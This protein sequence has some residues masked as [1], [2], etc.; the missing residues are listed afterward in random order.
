MSNAKYIKQ[1]NEMILKYQDDFDSLKELSK[2]VTS[3]EFLQVQRKLLK[4]IRRF[5]DGLCA[6]SV[7][8]GYGS[9][10][11]N[12]AEKFMGKVRENYPEIDYC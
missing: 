4:V 11:N 2:D 10:T 7:K 9:F 6:R 8:T 3:Q 5:E 1:Y 12:L